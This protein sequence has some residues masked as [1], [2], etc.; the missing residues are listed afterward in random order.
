MSAS[1]TPALCAA[2]SDTIVVAPVSNSAMVLWPFS[3]RVV[4]I[5]GILLRFS[6]S[7]SSSISE[8]GVSPAQYAMLVLAHSSLGHTR[9]IMPCARSYST[10]VA[11]RKLRPSRPMPPASSSLPPTTKSM[12]CSSPSSSC[13]SLTV[14]LR[15]SAML[16]A[17][18]WISMPNGRCDSGSFNCAAVDPVRMLKNAPLSTTIG[19]FVPLMPMVAIAR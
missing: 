10:S 1:L 3:S 6:R 16:P 9:R 15:A 8:T 2:L 5:A 12:S 19:T 11:A 17:T 14:V 7:C 4:R 18:P 13:T